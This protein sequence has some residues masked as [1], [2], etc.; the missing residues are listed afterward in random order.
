MRRFDVAFPGALLQTPAQYT[1]TARPPCRQAGARPRLRH[2][3]TR[4]PGNGWSDAASLTPA[5]RGRLMAM[6]REGG[7]VDRDG[8]GQPYHDA[9]T[10]RL[11][12]I[13]GG[14][15]CDVE[16]FFGMRRGPASREG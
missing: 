14:I 3:A 11:L 9:V 16:I 6:R 8:H 13:T 15:D 10:A 1:S 4:R 7:Q 2:T 5:V 12:E